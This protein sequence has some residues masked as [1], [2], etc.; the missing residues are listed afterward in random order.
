MNFIKGTWSLIKNN[1][2]KVAVVVVVAVVFL[3]STIAGMYNRARAA[4]PGGERL[5]APR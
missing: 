4:I 1:P 2:G 5:P 3:G